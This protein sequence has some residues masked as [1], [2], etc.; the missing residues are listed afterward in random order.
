LMQLQEFNDLVDICLQTFKLHLFGGEHQLSPEA[1]GC[2]FA[3]TV[4][5]LMR[6]WVFPF[7]VVLQ[8]LC[9]LIAE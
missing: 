5:Q 8:L 4:Y 6:T 9:Y 2:S 3:G 7:V 1:P